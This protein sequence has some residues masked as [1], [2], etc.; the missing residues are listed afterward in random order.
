MKIIWSLVLLILIAF[1]FFFT[2]KSGQ[3]RSKETF[4]PSRFMV[5]GDIPYDSR[6]SKQ[7]LDLYLQGRWS[8]EPNYFQIDKSPKPT[9]I[10]IHGGGWI[11]GDKADVVNWLMP[12]VK[13]GWNVVNLNYRIGDHTA[14]DAV[15]DVACAIKWSIEHAKTYNLNTQKIVLSGFSSGAH[16]ALIIGLLDRE[17]WPGPCRAGD[18]L[19][20]KAIINWFGI[21]DIERLENFLA[22]HGRPNYPLRWIGEKNHVGVV[23]K[24]FSPIHHV[25]GQSP[26][27]FTVHGD[28]DSV[29]PYEQATALHRVLDSNGVRNQLRTVAGGNHGGFSE[30]QYREA[31]M[32]IFG[33]LREI[34]VD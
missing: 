6:N 14:P 8:G 25:N 31:F 29:V 1:L 28:R 32:K 33:F 15:E 20:I 26:A 11:S 4:W 16:L 2:S 13:R 21:S 18:E 5:K 24:Q 27:I 19:R 7:R 34:G 22:A 17:R 10:Q 9:L 23:G 12:Y 30:A 3:L